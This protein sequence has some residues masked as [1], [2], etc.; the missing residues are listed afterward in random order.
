MA[1]A[2]LLNVATASPALAE[3]TS[4]LSTASVA[5]YCFGASV[6]VSGPGFYLQAATVSLTAGTYSLVGLHVT[7]AGL[8]V[9]AT[10]TFSLAPSSGTPIPG[11]SILYNVTYT[12]S[13]SAMQVLTAV[14]K[15]TTTTS[16]Y[17][18]V[19]DNTGTTHQGTIIATKIG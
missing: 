15:V 8:G 3:S 12:S 7:S 17:L 18:N 9:D 16:I 1:T 4:T 14:L 11:I 6:I 10:A 19:T 13:T 2:T 5:G